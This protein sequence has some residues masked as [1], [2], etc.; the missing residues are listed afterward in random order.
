[1][2][3][4]KI[5]AIVFSA[6][7]M[8]NMGTAVF[9]E[10]TYEDVQDKQPTITKTYQVNHGTAPVE[11]F[12]YNFEGVSYVNGDGNTVEGATIPAI[13][14]VTIAFD[15]AISAT[16]QKT[17]NVP[18]NADDYELGIYKY[19]VFE[20]LGTTAGVTYTDTNLYLVLTII[21]DESSNKHYVA[22][23]HYET[24][25]GS[26]TENGLTNSYDSNSL[27]VTKHI[28]GNMAEMSKKFTFTISFANPAGR[29]I[30]SAISTV[31]TSGTWS[32]DNLTYTVDLGNNEFV[33]FDNIPVGVSYTVS[34]DYENY[35]PDNAN[36]EVKGV[37]TA[38]EAVTAN[39]TNT[40]TNGTIDTGINLDSMP[41]IM[42]LAL[43]TVC[44]VV[45]FARKRF[46]ANR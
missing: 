17:V 11:T 46:S 38:D 40:L 6:M 45:M 15:E 37:I 35:E 30:K 34:E 1:M 20:A 25:N 43:V 12:T 31:G 39:F 5:A 13:S 4:K 16:T 44:A 32:E 14:P 7:M 19:R 33:K 36:G 22:A 18:I 23:L 8:L 29:E 42:I 27:T 26:K 41:Y 24:E 9:A 10:G 2:K 28:A 3:M 21:R